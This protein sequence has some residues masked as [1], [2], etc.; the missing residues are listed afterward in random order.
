MTQDQWIA[1]AFK[2]TLIADVAS[3][4]VF[5]GT[6]SVLAAWWRDTIGKTIVIKDIL[7][8][9]LLIPSLMSLFFRFNRLSSHIAAWV[10]VGLFTLMAGVMAWRCVVWVRIHRHGS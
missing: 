7:L 2:V 4:L 10:D 3:V 6:Y 8:V 5:I 1:V 9:L